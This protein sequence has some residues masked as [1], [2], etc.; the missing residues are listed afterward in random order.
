MRTFPFARLLATILI[1]GCVPPPPVVSV[2]DPE[3]THPKKLVVF[4][5]GTANHEGSY[6][7]V[8]RLHKLVTLQDNP[9]IGAVYIEGVGT[10]GRF[11]GMSMGWGIGVDVRNA[12]RYLGENYRPER[13]DEIY[14]FGFSRGAY[15]ARILAALLH[16]AGVPDLRGVPEAR[17]ADYVSSIYHAYKGDKSIAQRRQHIISATQLKPA[18]VPV[19]F[20]GLWDTVE[21]LGLPDYRENIEAP[22]SRY[23]DQLCNVA[24]AAHALSIDDNRAR[25][26]TPILLTR[27][28]LVKDCPS[29]NIDKVVD[30]VWFAGAHADVGGGYADTDIDGVSLNWMLSQIKDY[31]L[32][33]PNSRVFANPYGLTHNPERFMLGMLYKELN[34]NLPM[35]T[36]N[37]SY[38]GG[39]LKIHRSVLDRLAK[40]GVRSFESQ[41]FSS[42]RYKDC[43]THNGARAEYRP[44]QPCFDV[45]AY[46]SR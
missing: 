29:V 10:S 9:D 3:S 13:N 36:T 32:A 1:A 25:I 41:W 42:E 45:I 15:A 39:R 18:S 40:D 5:D 37:T 8:A 22:N 14:I 4:L 12:Y 11:I 17:R 30:E 44:D 35:Y 34:R 33:P 31:G 26:F 43:F 38:N 27:D 23:A 19:K 2:R 21:A 28:H 16:V 6:T 46:E 20:M 24:R 7:N